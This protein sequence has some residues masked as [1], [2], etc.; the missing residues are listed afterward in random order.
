MLVWCLFG[1]LY[2]FMYLFMIMFLIQCIEIRWFSEQYIKHS[3]FHKCCEL[4]FFS[5]GKWIIAFEC[6]FKNTTK[7]YPKQIPDII[8][9]SMSITSEIACHHQQLPCCIATNSAFSWIWIKFC[10]SYFIPLESFRAPMFHGW[11][12][13]A[14]LP[15][16]AC[17]TSASIQVSFQVFQASGE[18]V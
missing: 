10:F 4:F 2:I 18:Q 17:I 14:G 12:V 15:R 9:V 16:V 11:M 8:V 5:S 7:T 3:V 6:I 1:F 13:N